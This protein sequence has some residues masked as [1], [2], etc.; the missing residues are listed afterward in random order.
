MKRKQKTKKISVIAL[1][2]IV[3]IAFTYD[4]STSLK[5]S[6]TSNS[7]KLE[8]EFNP[9][10]PEEPA[11][12]AVVTSDYSGL[13]SQVDRNVDPGYEHIEE[14]VRKAIELQGGL[15]GV[16]EKGDTVMLKVNLVGGNSPSGEGENT[17]VR[18]VKALIK[19]IYDFQNDV[20]ITVAEGTARTNDDFNDEGSVW[21]NSGYVDLLTDADLTGIDFNF[22]NL[23]QTINDLV[24]VNLGEKGTAE[25]YDYTFHVH[26]K[27]VEADVYISVP[28]L[29]IHNPGITC[30][31]K[32]Q[33]GT[34]PGCYYGYNKT[35]QKEKDGT[36]TP[37]K[38]LHGSYAPQDWTEEEIV[39]LSSIADIDFVVVDAV[40]C[41]QTS[42]GYNGSNQLRMNT[43]IAGKD[44]VAAD[45]VC[46]KLLGLNPDD[47][48][49][50][51]LAEK[52]GLGT[53]NPDYINVVGVPITNAMKKAKKSLSASGRFGRSNRTWILSSAFEGTDIT[54][55]Y[56]SDEATY[57]PEA[58]KEGWSQPVY[59][60]DDQ[61]DLYSYYN[62][63]TDIVTYAFTHFYSPDFI[64]AEFWIGK[65]EAM[66]VYV[67]G[68]LAYSF[69]SINSYEENEYGEKVGTIN[70]KQGENTLLVKTLNTYG[71]Y[72]FA[73]NIC[74]EE[75][76]ENYYGNRIPGLK[77]YISSNSDSDSNQYKLINTSICAGDSYFAQGAHQTQSGTYYDTVP[78]DAIDTIIVTMLNVYPLP[79]VNLGEDKTIKKPNSLYLNAGFG[80]ESYLWNTDETNQ[81]IK[82]NSSEETAPKRDYWVVVTDENGCLNSD[83]ISILFEEKEEET[84]EDSVVSISNYK[85]SESVKV[86]PNPTSGDINIAFNDIDGQISIQVIT[87]L[88]QI[89]YSK[90]YNNFEKNNIKHINL[91]DYPSGNYFVVISTNEK[92][93]K[94]S[95][96]IFK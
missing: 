46:T 83:T 34:A 23:N 66:Y 76:D 87:E 88:G 55:E 7:F 77:F 56:I 91:S 82:I 92:I 5:V 58:G 20:T 96:I 60:F 75:D 14:M 49:H 53:N 31:L 38:L 79:E 74:E 15:D 86:Y 26:K 42:K 3:L 94:K 40:M 63:S 4:M 90:Q 36:P 19:T 59:F 51:C 84:E 17:D 85:N 21:H 57:I 95:F 27:E 52:T 8:S 50:I 71:S 2:S 35:K 28:V 11:K 80:F 24:A 25:P 44:P 18:V 62:G 37:S 10:I 81:T 30:V 16:I 9:I 43:I 29:K 64:T 73:L 33:I 39:D 70:L 93:Y 48:D 22:L 72:T 6:I 61:I 32:N 47:I 13:S 54:E 41:L 45:H 67:N 12:I 78:G 65:Q 89:I 1:I 69:T 68:E